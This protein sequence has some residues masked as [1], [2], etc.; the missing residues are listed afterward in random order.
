MN[1]R[2]IEKNE[3]KLIAE[4]TQKLFEDEP[5]DMTLS[6]EDF[7]NRLLNY[8]NAGCEAFLFT[9]NEV[10][11]YALVNIARNPYYL[12]DFFICRHHRRNGK[13]TTAFHVLMNELN[14]ES[15]DLDV[16]CWNDRGRKFWESLGFK[17]RAIIM[18]KS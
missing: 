14:T 4:M 7:E 5:S 8:I 10:I 3:I 11:G 13:G 2:K 1:I 16:F 18:R 6:I 17:E 12:I 9:E 15:I